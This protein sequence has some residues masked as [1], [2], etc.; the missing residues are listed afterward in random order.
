MRRWDRAGD[1][2]CR[3]LDQGESWP[4]QDEAL[5][6]AHHD[7]LTRNVQGDPQL[8]GRASEDAA[9]SIPDCEKLPFGEMH[10]PVVE[11]DRNRRDA[12]NIL[13]PEKGKEPRQPAAQAIREAAAFGSKSD[14]DRTEHG[15]VAQSTGSF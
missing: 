12:M 10:H 2:A 13:S 5:G 14:M 1:T 15:L 9:A 4:I 3:G 6:R 11:G 7:I 8:C